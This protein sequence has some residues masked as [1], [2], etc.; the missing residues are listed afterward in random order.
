MGKKQAMLTLDEDV[1]AGLKAR[2]D[3]M[4]L[5][6]DEWVE[7]MLRKELG[8]DLLDRLQHRN[9]LSGAEAMVLA[10]EA[11]RAVRQT[12]GH[13]LE[14]AYRAAWEEI[15]DTSGYNDDSLTD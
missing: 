10:L 8:F 11:Q 2:S 15:G 1:L 6:V 12:K 5:S 3:R 13:G 14:E 9:N 7:R 4:G